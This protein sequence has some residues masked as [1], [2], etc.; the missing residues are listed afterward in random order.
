MPQ[1]GRAHFFNRRAP[2]GE[3]KKLFFASSACPVKSHW[4][5]QLGRLCGFKAKGRPEPAEGSK[6]GVPNFGCGFA[7][8]GIDYGHDHG[9]NFSKRAERG[10]NVEKNEGI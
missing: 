2:I 7:T 10:G 9:Y 8:S 6:G 5:I 1:R 3:M 4:A